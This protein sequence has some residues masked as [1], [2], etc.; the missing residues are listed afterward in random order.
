MAFVVNLL[1][2]GAVETEEGSRP[3]LAPWTGYGS[4]DG[5]VMFEGLFYMGDGATAIAAFILGVIVLVIGHIVV[6]LLG[7]TSAGLQAIR[8]EYVEFFGKFYEGG[9]KNYEPFGHDRN[10]SE[11]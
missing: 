3:F 9:G 10:H 7:I 1:V 5:E 2:F 11:D 6:L 8:L 4:G